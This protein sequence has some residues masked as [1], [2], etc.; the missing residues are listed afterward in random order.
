MMKTYDQW[1]YHENKTLKSPFHGKEYSIHD[2]NKN[3][4]TFSFFLRLK[5]CLK[6]SLDKQCIA[7]YAQI[8]NTSIQ[9]FELVFGKFLQT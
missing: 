9:W 1:E 5:V 7:T 3:I 2:G 4:K 6:F 8:Q